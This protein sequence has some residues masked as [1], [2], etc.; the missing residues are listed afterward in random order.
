MTVSCKN[1]IGRAYKQHK[2]QTDGKCD[3]QEKLQ[4]I[5]LTSH[6]TQISAFNEFDFCD[7]T[8]I[9]N[10]FNNVHYFLYAFLYFDGTFNGIAS[11][12]CQ[13]VCLSVCLSG[14]CRPNRQLQDLKARYSWLALWEEDAYFFQNRWLKVKV[15]L[16]L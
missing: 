5:K 12:V 16:S 14:H 6:M 8:S 4:I 15:E 9:R 2:H 7:I 13:S 1:L 10:N 3:Y 11:S